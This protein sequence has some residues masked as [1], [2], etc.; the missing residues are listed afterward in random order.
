ML[1]LSRD[2]EEV[3]NAAMLLGM[4]GCCCY[5]ALLSTAIG[6][7]RTGGTN[8]ACFRDLSEEGFTANRVQA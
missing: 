1:M 6:R 5:L 4:S 7:M 3:L 2:Q 8:V